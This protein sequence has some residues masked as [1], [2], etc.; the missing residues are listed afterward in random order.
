MLEFS[1]FAEITG[2]YKLFG[3][4]DSQRSH[5]AIRVTICGL[6]DEQHG[7]CS[8]IEGH[9]CSHCCSGKAISITNSES[10]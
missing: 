4:P 5:C 8:Y 10:V 6:Q 9:S 1:T 3:T 2:N 7:Q